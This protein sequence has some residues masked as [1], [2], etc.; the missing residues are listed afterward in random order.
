MIHTRIGGINL[1][2]EDRLQNFLQGIY[3][4]ISCNNLSPTKF[5][6]DFAL[7]EAFP[8]DQIEK[9]TQD[10]CFNYA[11]MLYQ[12]AD[13]VASERASCETTARWCENSLNSIISSEMEDIAH[14]IAKH[15]IKVA[16]ILRTNDLARKIN[17]WKL[18]AE[19]RLE[20][21]KSR[22]YNVRRKADILIEK[23]KRK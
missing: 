10:E 18:T 23:G 13:H 5:R 19:G 22:E 3:N 2:L 11:Y 20:P 1:N 4:Y 6:A 7:V 21:L 14:V 8:L 15:E 9:L 12:Y 16:S 17:E